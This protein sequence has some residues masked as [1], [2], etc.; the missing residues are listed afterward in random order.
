MNRML[1]VTLSAVV[2]AATVSTLGTVRAQQGTAQP[3]AGAPQRG[4]QPPGGPGGGGGRGRGPIVPPV[5]FEDRTGFESIFDGKSLTPGATARAAARAAAAAKQAD[6][7]KAAAAAGQPAPTG[8]GRGGFGGGP[9]PSLFQDW[10]GDPK[11]WRV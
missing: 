4:Q 5:A 6:E 1:A 2:A 11:F 9:Q 3:A 10:D 8:R 7:A